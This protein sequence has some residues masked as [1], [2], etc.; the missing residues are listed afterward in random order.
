MRPPRADVVAAGGYALTLDVGLRNDATAIAVGHVESHTRGHDAPPVR[1]LV[2]DAVTILKPEAGRRVTI[3]EVEGATAALAGRYGCREV[4]AD[5]H[6][7]DALRPRLATR[8]IG[9]REMNMA[10]SAQETRAKTLAALFSSRAVR[11]VDNATTTTSELIDLRVERHAGGR[12]TIAASGSRHDDA[13]DTL[14]LLAEVSTSL[15]ACG[16]ETGVE[17]FAHD[18][19]GWT[20]EG[21]DTR[22]PRWVR[23]LTNGST[24]LAS[25]PAG[26]PAGRT[27]RAH[28]SRSRWAAAP[29]E[30]M[31]WEREQAA[32]GMT[33]P[34]R[35]VERRGIDESHGK[36][37]HPSIETG[38]GRRA[39]RAPRH[40]P[41]RRDDP[42]TRAGD[43]RSS[44]RRGPRARSSRRT[45]SS[46]AVGRAY[47]QLVVLNDEVYKRTRDP[48]FVRGV[49]RA[50]E[51]VLATSPTTPGGAPFREMEK[52]FVQNQQLTAAQG[53]AAAAALELAKAK[54]DPLTASIAEGPQKVLNAIESAR[55]GVRCS[56]RTAGQGR[57]DRL[58]G[59]ARRRRR[60]SRAARPA[61]YCLK[62]L[63]RFVQG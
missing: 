6:M 38:Q 47:S 37:G 35:A 26:L 30:I 15:P 29:A 61:S 7:A 18:G 9:F 23:T 36:R 17:E 11:L 1:A 44:R 40:L 53:D 51:M 63:D 57:T 60:D 8:G 14:L 2:L 5:L 41:V 3:D 62:Q 32:Q 13:A 4:A 46:S 10:P 39:A 22:N 12:V 28:P 20:E 21:V 19:V 16:G 54:L 56:G 49:Q 45:G 27:T 34:S 50:T 33:S 42:G 55:G 43:R 24:E 59:P 25:I 58:A 48:Q 52:T 31:R